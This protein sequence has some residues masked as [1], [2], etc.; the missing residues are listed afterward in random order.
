MEDVIIIGAGPAGLTSAI[1]TARAGLRTKVFEKAVPGGQAI[2]SD[3]IENYPGFP[4]GISGFLLMDRIRR[5]AER[6]KVEINIAEVKGVDV[7]GKIKKVYTE[8]EVFEAKALIIC[9]GSQPKR[10]GIKGEER[11][12]G[13]GVSFCATCDGPF[14]KGQTVAVI[15]GGDSAV[16]EA[17]F[18]TRF[19]NKV[20]LIHRRERLR[21]AKILQ[22]RALNEKKIELILNTVPERIE[23]EEKVEAIILRNLKDGTL[24]ELPVQGVFVF[25]GALPNSSFLE[26]KLKTDNEGYIITDQN[27]QTSEKGVFAAGDVRSKQLRQ[28][29]TAV[30]DGAIAAFSAEKYIEENF[31]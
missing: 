29:A 2:N 24:K 20:Y 14:F 5:Q 16:Q 4:E 31:R 26:G 21:A 17:L 23:G 12:I 6:L 8:N 15:G 18:L 1:Y 19:A 11:L 27:M 22:K 3:L 9:T 13:K 25:I 7:S 30:G 28:I 10:L